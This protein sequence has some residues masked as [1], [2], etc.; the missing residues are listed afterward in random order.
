VSTVRPAFEVETFEYVEAGPGL[1]LMR[2]AG[3]WRAGDPPGRTDLVAV[4]GGER[5]PLSPLPPPPATGAD[6]LW[7]AAFSTSPRRLGAAFELDPPAGESIPLPAPAEHATAAASPAPDMEAGEPQDS[8]RAVEAVR[9]LASAR[10]A[11]DKANARSRQLETA[12]VDT[13]ARLADREAL[14]ERARTNAARAVRESAEIE[15]AAT[16]LRD[17]IVARE[18]AGVG[19][20]ASRRARESDELRSAR[21]EVRQGAERVAALERQAEALREAI[22]S[23]LPPSLHASPLQEV[24]PLAD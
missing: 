8:A 20:D 9:A 5:V 12:L 13:R 21:E 24:L 14:I 6:G 22:H 18:R 10:R 1:V 4:S 15:A 11:R 23:Q 2:L 17:A 7:R 3:T 16:R 19:G